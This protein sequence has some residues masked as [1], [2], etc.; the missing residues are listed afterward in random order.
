MVLW[1]ELYSHKEFATVLIL[2]PP[3]GPAEVA[4]FG[5]EVFAIDQVKMKSLG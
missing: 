2:P 4:L 1:V 5:N 3:P